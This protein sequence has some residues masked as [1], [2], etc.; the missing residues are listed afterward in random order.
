MTAPF[1]DVVRFVDADP[2]GLA[3]MVGG[4]IAQNLARDP[5][6]ARLLRP[7]LASIE[8][9]DADVGITMRIA[10]GS[11][12]IADGLDPAAD[13]RIT[14][15]SST[16]LDLANVPLR[17]GLPDV[18]DRA[19]RAVIGELLAR[20]LRVGGLSHPRRVADLTMLL[21]VHEHERPDHR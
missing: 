6:R 21:S 4:L 20:R 3:T 9:P 13:V 5:D 8:V 12:V 7:S 19:G 1:D 2:S 10:P 11:V 18:F 14:A 15:G 17:M 16:L